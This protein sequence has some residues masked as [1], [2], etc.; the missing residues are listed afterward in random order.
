MLR[1]ARL[2]GELKFENTKLLIF[3]DYT[4]EPQRQRKAFDHVRGMLRQKGVKYS[5]LFPA[6][7]R[8]QDGEKVQFFTSPRE[9]ARW[10]ES[11]PN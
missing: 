2:Q 10:A 6:R 5:M 8:V 7:L 11:L 3:P 1:A 9:A 4:V